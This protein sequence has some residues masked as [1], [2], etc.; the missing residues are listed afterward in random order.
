MGLNLMTRCHSCFHDTVSPET[1]C[2]GA[3]VR[4]NGVLH[5]FQVPELHILRCSE[6]G[7][8]H[9]DDQSDE[10]VEATLDT[11]LAKSQSLPGDEQ[12]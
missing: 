9:F 6:C 12:V 11:I 7:M 1:V 8:L 4:R 3:C 2:Y 5:T 10:E